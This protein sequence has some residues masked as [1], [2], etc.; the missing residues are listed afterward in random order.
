VDLTSILIEDGYLKTK[1][2]IEA[3]KII[4]RK[5]FLPKNVKKLSEQNSALPI[6][7]SQTISQPLTVAF[8]LEL[9]S[10]QTGEKILDI[11]SGSGFTTA[12]LSCIVGKK[13][14][15]IALEIIPELLKVGEEN[16][17]K[18]NFVKKGIA[19]F[20]LGDGK[21]GYKK[22]APFDKILCSAEAEFV[23]DSLKEQLK[24]GGKIVI[25]VKSSIILLEKKRNGNFDKKEFYGFSFV[26]LV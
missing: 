13:G 12:I 15:V 10:P 5:D 22:E 19:S 14:K 3:F 25:P 20:I 21:K 24:T 6:G 18:Y 1:E 2:I 8:M 16:V 4:K 9:L 7:Y 11:G 26:P 17:S 23:P